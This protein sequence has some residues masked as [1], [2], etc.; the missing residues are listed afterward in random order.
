MTFFGHENEPF[1]TGLYISFAI[2]SG[3]LFFLQIFYLQKLRMLPVYLL[4]AISVC[5]CWENSL[6]AGGNRTETYWRI[7]QFVT[8][9]QALILPFHVIVIFEMPFR[10]HQA[11]TAHFLCIPFEQGEMISGFIS[12]ICLWSVRIIALGLLVI[13]LLVNFNLPH[14]HEMAGKVGFVYFNDIENNTHMWLALL[15]PLLLSLEST[16]I[17]V[18][19][20]RYAKDFSLGVRNQN[21][22]WRYL[23]PISLIYAAT[24]A[25]GR[26]LYPV[27]SNGGDLCLLIGESIMTYRVQLDLAVAGSFADFLHRSNIVFSGSQ[28]KKSTTPASDVHHHHPHPHH[29]HHHHHHTNNN[30]N[31][32]NHTKQLQSTAGEYAL[33]PTKQQSDSLTLGTDLEMNSSGIELSST[34]G[35]NSDSATIT[36]TATTATTT[37]HNNKQSNGPYQE[38]IQRDTLSSDVNENDIDITLTDTY[39]SNTPTN[40]NELE[41]TGENE[42]KMNELSIDEKGRLPRVSIGSISG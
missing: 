27:L 16:I 41:Y 11:R 25:F 19:M 37:I 31:D 42:I 21:Y 17:S 34:S 15:P 12:K 18:V 22:Y 33:V 35:M 13:N 14:G 38:V 30:N 20:Q 26:R 10:L 39:N 23:L 24:H 9:I 7:S 4:P 28:R 5:I 32:P 3:L 36:T 2:I 40:A 1:E 8:A 29:P 6:L